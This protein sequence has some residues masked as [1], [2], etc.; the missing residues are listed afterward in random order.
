MN[1]TPGPWVSDTDNR[2][3]VNRVVARG[4][5]ISHVFAGQRKLQTIEQYDKETEANA[6]L[7]AAA[8]EL[9]EAANKCYE[10]HRLLLSKIGAAGH[11]YSDAT[12]EWVCDPWTQAFKDLGKAIAKA[13]GE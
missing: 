6:N 5:I 9:L 7:I 4:S 1:H 12:G 3:L 8:P 11:R 13:K 2:R 10:F